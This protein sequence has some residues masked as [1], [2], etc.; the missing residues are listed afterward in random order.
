[1]TVL[2]ILVPISFFA[3]VVLCTYFISKYRSETITKLGGPVPRLPK[4]PVSW[5]K[6]GIVVIGFAVGT[7][8]S[9]MMYATSM[10]NNSGWDGLIIIGTITLTVGVSFIIADKKENKEDQ[11]IDG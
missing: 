5:R 4:N 3:C 8:A 7:L 2:G 11:G 1:M 6:I 10:L 9:G